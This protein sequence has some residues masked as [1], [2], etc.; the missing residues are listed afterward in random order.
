MLIPLLRPIKL[1]IFEHY[2]EGFDEI[3]AELRDSTIVPIL[4]NPYQV[5]R[6][7]PHLYQAQHSSRSLQSFSF[8]TRYNP[9]RSLH[10]FSSLPGASWSFLGY[11]IL[12]T[13]SILLLLLRSTTIPLTSQS[14]K[15]LPYYQIKCPTILSKSKIFLTS[16]QSEILRYTPESRR[17]R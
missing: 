10:T 9:F 3:A 2:Q 6:Y 17:Y 14:L 16:V 11:T 13:P 5:L 8:L 1:N 7:N 12:C 15:S 4:L